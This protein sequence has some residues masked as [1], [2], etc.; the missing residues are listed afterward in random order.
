MVTSR[1]WMAAFVMTLAFVTVMAQERK[2]FEGIMKVQGF[3]NENTTK[4]NR[5]LTA[6]W[7]PDGMIV[8][9]YKKGKMH[10]I[11]SLRRMHTIYDTEKHLM[12][13]Y[14]ELLGQGISMPLDDKDVKSN[15]MVK[16]QAEPT[17]EQAELQG[18]PC[19]KWELKISF[20]KIIKGMA[21]VAA[22][23][24]Q[25]EPT[26]ELW[27]SREYLPIKDFM[28]VI[29]Y[30]GLVLQRMTTSSTS[31]TFYSANTYSDETLLSIQAQPVSD[32]LFQ[33]PADIQIKPCKGSYAFMTGCWKMFKENQKVM[34]KMGIKLE[35]QK[36][37]FKTNE[38]FDE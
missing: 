14:Y 15:A 33:V 19:D 22:G 16:Y 4:Q 30:P 38:E 3:I 7:S 36:T 18:H 5:G 2:P 37:Q 26:Q 20:N 27:I 24:K 1:K 25:Q 29:R 8:R 35:E 32:D 9:I 13:R 31:S 12:I 6:L 28:S 21:K 17:G 10:E 34:Q 11:D 23:T